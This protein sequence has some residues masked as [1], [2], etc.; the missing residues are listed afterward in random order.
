MLW[1][2]LGEFLAGFERMRKWHTQYT[3][4]T[5]QILGDRAFET[6]RR[7]GRQLTAEQAIAYALGEQDIPPAAAEPS[8]ARTLLTR[9][10]AE[11]ATLVAE[12]MT[13]KEIARSLVIAPRTVEGHVEHILTKL[14]FTSRTQVAALFAGKR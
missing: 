9:R 5:V 12:G 3:L 14:G 13:N 2:P 8:D 6:A 1:E 10:E 7:S 11:I 4:R